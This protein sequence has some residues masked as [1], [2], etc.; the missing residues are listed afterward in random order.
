M[1]FFDDGVSR[2]SIRAVLRSTEARVSTPLL[3]GLRRS[4]IRLAAARMEPE[5][6]RLFDV[7]VKAAGW[8]IRSLMNSPFPVAL[9]YHAV[10]GRTRPKVLVQG[11]PHRH[12]PARLDDVRG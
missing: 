8:R 9:G 2:S 12:Q 11:N 1:T 3:V 6:V 7:H 10:N 4:D 5:N